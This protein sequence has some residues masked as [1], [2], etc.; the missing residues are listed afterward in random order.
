MGKNKEL[1]FEFKTR[2]LTE[3]KNELPIKNK[4]KV[5]NGDLKEYLDKMKPYVKK[6]VIVKAIQ[7][8]KDFEVD[9]LE[10]KMKGKVGDWLMCGVE[11]ELHICKNSIFEKTYEEPSSNWKTPSFNG[12]PVVKEDECYVWMNCDTGED[13]IDTVV[14]GYVSDVYKNMEKW[15]ESYIYMIIPKP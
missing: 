11:N 14:E 13:G 10:G 3:D 5:S 2:G 8:D 7:M 4:R 12:L 6:K 15:P 1:F 9:T